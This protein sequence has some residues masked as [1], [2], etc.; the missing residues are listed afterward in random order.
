M[1][2]SWEIAWKRVPLWEITSTRVD[3]RSTVNVIIHGFSLNEVG[4]S[5]SQRSTVDAIISGF[6]LNTVCIKTM[7]T[8]DPS[9]I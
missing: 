2:G 5:G 4:K 6:P 1:F 8:N 9:R 7:A 3:Q